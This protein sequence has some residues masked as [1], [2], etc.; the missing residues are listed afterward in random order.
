MT[1]FDNSE[2][3]LPGARVCVCI[4]VQLYNLYAYIVV[5]I[6]LYNVPGYRLLGVRMSGDDVAPL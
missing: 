5:G 3:E 2:T 6:Q 1:A 4:P